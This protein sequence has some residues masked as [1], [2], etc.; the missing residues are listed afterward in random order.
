LRFLRQQSKTRP[1]VGATDSAAVLANAQAH[2]GIARAFDRVFKKSKPEIL[3]LGPISGQTVVYMADRG[4]RVS[5]EE[6][7]RLAPLPKPAPGEKVDDIV[8]EPFRIDQPGG[9]F[10]LVL[11]WEQCDFVPP[12]RLGEFMAEI[13]RV[14]ADGGWL[15]L[16]SRNAGMN[17]RAKTTEET[18]IQSRYR[19]V[20]D[21]M[22]V[23][24]PSGR[25]AGRR[26]VH[27]TREIERA[28]APLAV[29]GIHLQRNQIREFSALKKAP[30]A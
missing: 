28:L 16:F 15:L 6:V 29:Q 17:P 26:W 13:R 18:A 5:V 22:A 10:D 24:E 12:Q 1:V 3:D 2:P 19:L 30:R 27:P 21:K 11:A 8:V 7:E 20:D 4:A 25:T 23:R 9:K 14:M